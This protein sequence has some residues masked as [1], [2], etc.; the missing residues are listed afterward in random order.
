MFFWEKGSQSSWIY[1]NKIQTKETCTMPV[2]LSRR[3]AR[4]RVLL[5]LPAGAGREL[6]ARASSAQMYQMRPRVQTTVYQ[7][8]P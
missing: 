4:A 2:E 1:I 7:E 5:P 6:D 8:E 3:L